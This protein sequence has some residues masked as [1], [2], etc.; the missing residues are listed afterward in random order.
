M[1]IL[2]YGYVQKTV[3]WPPT[4]SN[5][6]SANDEQ[7]HQTWVAYF[8]T[9]PWRPENQ[10]GFQQQTL[11]IQLNRQSQ[12]SNA[13]PM[14]RQEI[15]G[16]Q[17]HPAQKSVLIELNFIVQGSISKKEVI[18]KN[19][20]EINIDIFQII[21]ISWDFSSHSEKTSPV[22]TSPPTS[23]TASS[24]VTGRSP[25]EDGHRVCAQSGRDHL[26][27]RNS[28]WRLTVRWENPRRKFAGIFQPRLMTPEGGWFFLFF[29]NIIFVVD[30]IIMY[31]IVHV[32][33]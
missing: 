3:D 29:R 8:Q 28:S 26:S 25:R 15:D 7:P 10:P 9:K 30:R 12:L 32:F 18:Y 2:I 4:Y 22:P 24:L 27:P 23:S 31:Y 1:D 13:G 21:E 11:G 33:S 16:I 17:H 6:S 20:I 14:N 5:F 19:K